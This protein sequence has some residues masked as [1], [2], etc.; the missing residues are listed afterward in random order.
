VHGLHALS[1]WFF[2]NFAGVRNLWNAVGVAAT[3]GH[4]NAFFYRINNGDR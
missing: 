2:D 3:Q 4:Q 1:I